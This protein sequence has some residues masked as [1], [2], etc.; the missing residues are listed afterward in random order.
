MHQAVGLAMCG[1]AGAY[2]DVL[3]ETIHPCVSKAVVFSWGV[4]LR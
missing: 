2:L 1:E 4:P 3:A